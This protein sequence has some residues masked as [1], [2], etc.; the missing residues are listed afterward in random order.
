M[1]NTPISLVYGL[2]FWAQ[3]ALAV[4]PHNRKKPRLSW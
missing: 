2:F 3:H 1:R 4:I